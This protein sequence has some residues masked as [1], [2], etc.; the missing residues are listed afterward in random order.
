[1]RADRSAPVLPQGSRIDFELPPLTLMAISEGLATV[2]N[3]CVSSTYPRTHG[4]L[5][6]FGR[7]P[8]NN[9]SK[10]SPATP[11]QL[12]PASPPYSETLRE[13]AEAA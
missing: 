6:R 11:L 7:R 12:T 4:Q 9:L 2:T 10:I 8:R 1:M 13:G 3:T 5:V